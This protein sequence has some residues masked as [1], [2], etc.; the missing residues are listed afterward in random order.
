MEHPY[1]K[2]VG[3][4]PDLDWDLKLDNLFHQFHHSE[5]RFKIK[6]FLS[7]EL[8]LQEL[9]QSQTQKF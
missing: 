2:P 1:D 9:E 7:I 3:I 6:S 5:L 4:G 8:M